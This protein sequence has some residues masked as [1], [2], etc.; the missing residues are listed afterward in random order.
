[1]TEGWLSLKLEN[2]FIHPFE[3]YFIPFWRIS[4]SSEMLVYGIH[5]LHLSD[6]L[7]QYHRSE[8]L[9]DKLNEKKYKYFTQCVQTWEI[10]QHGWIIYPIFVFASQ[11]GQIAVQVQSSVAVFIHRNHSLSNKRQSSQ[12]SKVLCKHFT[13][14]YFLPKIF[15]KQFPCYCIL[16]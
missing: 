16:Q 13:L 2:I 10:T 7:Q 15:H 3:D 12:A 5:I 8:I 14:N 11:N 4:Y 9:L 6:L 1:M